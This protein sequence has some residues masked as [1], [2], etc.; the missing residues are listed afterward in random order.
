MIYRD[1]QIT[2]KNGIILCN[3]ASQTRKKEVMITKFCFEKLGIPIIGEI[4]TPGKMEG[5][6]NYE[7]INITLKKGGDF[8][9]CGE[10]YCF[11]GVG[12]RTNMHAI[13]Y[14]L[15]N[16]LFGTNYVFVVKDCFDWNQQVHIIYSKKLII[17]FR[18]CI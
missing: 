9:P 2:T 1:Q 3:L 12:L 7:F 11:I 17:L 10:N 15:D 18:E 16:D 8:I 4:K 5:I 13:H 6:E 14:C